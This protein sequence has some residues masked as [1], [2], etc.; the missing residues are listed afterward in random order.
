MI[1]WAVALVLFVPQDAALRHVEEI[2][3]STH[4]YRV[5]QGG[6][7]D[8][9]NCRSP[10]GG[11]FGI[12]TQSWESNRA[13]R[14]E[15]VGDTDLLD[16]WLSNGRNDFRSVK[17]IVAGT[18]KPGMTD[19][20]RALAI[21]RRQTTHRFH[22]GAG[23][24]AEMHDPS[25]STTS[26]ATTPAGTTPSASPASGIRPDSGQSRPAP[27]T[28]HLAGVLRR[29]LE[30]DGRRHGPDLPAPRQQTIACEQ[31]LVRDHDL[32]KRSHPHGSSIPIGG[33]TTKS[34]PRCSSRTWRRRPTRDRGD[35]PAVD[36]EH[37]APPRS[38]SS[39]AGAGERNIT[40]TTTSAFS[41]P[42]SADG[43]VWGA[44]AVGKDLQRPVGVSA[45]LQRRRMA[46]GA[47]IRDRR[48]SLRQG[49]LSGGTVVWRMKSPY[50]FV[51]G[52]LEIV[53][54]GVRSSSPGTG[55]AWEPAGENL[56]PH[57]PRAG[58]ARYEYRPEVRA[59]GRR[60]ARAVGDPQ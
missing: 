47:R 43:R 46:S 19:R 53:G 2:S 18:A 56:D 54:R 44:S 55:T 12:W 14:L 1:R 48:S 24:A 38:R 4:A 22:G 8:G 20:E 26:T 35:R 29:P 15:N 58:P 60:E 33:R 32:V 9:V 57:F 40:V 34:T 50:V 17:E 30:P 13:V 41:A 39:G 3:A 49:A 31:D 6:T 28:P 11:G 27:R 21:W 59:S 36:H 10:I 7:M 16:P 45:R 42:E 51:G 25:R 5:T 23:D 52:R 37:G